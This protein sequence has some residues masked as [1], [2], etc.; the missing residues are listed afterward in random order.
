MYVHF[1]ILGVLGVLALPVLAVST[2]NITTW[3]SDEPPKNPYLGPL[4]C[5]QP[6]HGLPGKNPHL[7]PT[8]I[9]AH[10]CLNR[11]LEEMKEL[12]TRRPP[13]SSTWARSSPEA[14]FMVP[15][16]FVAKMKFSN[17]CAARIVMLEGF[18]GV[19][20]QGIWEFIHG[21]EYIHTHC[22][23][24]RQGGYGLGGSIPVGRYMGVSLFG[25]P[26]GWPPSHSR[27]LHGFSN[28]TGYVD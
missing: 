1:L 17:G 19:V 14:D 8:G 10:H 24:D 5:F 11:V 28:V 6:G 13:E 23:A 16:F 12:D 25:I 21:V 7:L 15:R 27:P 18:N 22:A 3:H 9:H 4:L 26:A 2:P 20:R